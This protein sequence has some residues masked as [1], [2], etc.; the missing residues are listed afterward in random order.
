M[1]S[2]EKGLNAFNFISILRQAFENCEDK[3]NVFQRLKLGEKK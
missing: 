1:I 3:S 2:I